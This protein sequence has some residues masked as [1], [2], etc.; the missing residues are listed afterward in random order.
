MFANATFRW[1]FVTW[2]FFSL[3]AI[4]SALLTLSAFILGL[5]CRLNFGKGLLRYCM[6]P[7]L[8]LLACIVR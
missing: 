7:F 3:I 8:L 4:A 2:Q 5:V 6:P 1:T